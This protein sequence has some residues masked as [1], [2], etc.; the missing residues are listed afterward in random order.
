MSTPCIITVA[1]TGSLPR[2]ENNP[3]VPDHGRRA[4]RID[5]G[6]LRGRRHAGASACAQ[7]RPDAD[8][9]PGAVRAPAR[10]AAPALPGHD[11][12]VLDRRPL[13]RGPGARRHAA[14]EARHGLARHRLVQLPDPGLRER[15]RPDRLARERDAGARGQARDRGV[16]PVDDLQGGRDGAGGQD[17]RAACMSSSSWASR[18]PCRSTAQ[19]LEF[20]VADAQAP[21]ARRNLDRR[22]ASA[23]TS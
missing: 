6:G 15:A 12:A 13:R 10:R 3:A 16:R 5:P 17:Q 4:G 21:G 18:T 8:L 11:P 20:Y 23:R 7:R 2:K 22:R 1:I 9:R 19:V 14:P